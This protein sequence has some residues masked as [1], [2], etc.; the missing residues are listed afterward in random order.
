MSQVGQSSPP[1]CSQTQTMFYGE[2]ALLPGERTHLYMRC[3]YFSFGNKTDMLVNQRSH[4]SVGSFYL[5]QTFYFEG[6][7]I[8]LIFVSRARVVVLN[9]KVKP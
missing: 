6:I 2:S 4:S 7:L 1:H 8:V 5:S 3:V 9:A